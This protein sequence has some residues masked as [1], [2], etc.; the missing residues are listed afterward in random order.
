MVP[1]LCGQDIELGNFILGDEER[2]STGA[3]ASRALLRDIDGYP[4]G[5]ALAPA[6]GRLCPCGCG[7]ILAGSG[8][9]ADAQDWGRKWLENGS[10]FYIDLNHLELASRRRRARTTT[11]RART[12]CCASRRGPSRRR[13]RA[14]RRAA[15]SRRWSTTAT[16]TGTA[17]AATR[18]PHDAPAWDQIFRTACTTCSTW[19]PSRS[20]AS[21]SPDRARSAR[22]TAAR[23]PVPAVAACRLLRDDDRAADHLR[24]PIV[25]SRDEALCGGWRRTRAPARP[26]RWPP[27]RHLLRQHALPLSHA[28]EDRDDAD[29]PRHDRAGPR[30]PLADPRRSPRRRPPLEPRSDAARARR[31]RR[32]AALTAV[33]LQSAFLDE[34]QR[35]A[36]SGGC[37]GI[38][39]R[40]A[41]I[42]ALWGRVLE[43]MRAGD[44][45][46]RG[47]ARLGP[48]TIPAPASH[49]PTPGSV[50]GLAPDQAPRLDS[51]RVSRQTRACS[52]RASRRVSSSA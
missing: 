20:R 23:R 25:N 29:R 30:G 18:L 51:T 34:A 35:F 42:V 4:A 47:A 50:V 11:W 17:T 39:P 22:R 28:P 7:T 40:A 46:P 48:E 44:S 26:T 13:T 36:A 27:A 3:E 21:S 49:G 15:R 24:R 6:G 19:R 45:I 8:A 2:S 12:R 37:D 31:A 38:V 43:T 33:E 41:E 14:G 16:A 32:R 52:G 10:C 1:K 5:R 9:G